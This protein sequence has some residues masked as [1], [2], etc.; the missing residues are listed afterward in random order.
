MLLKLYEGSRTYAPLWSDPEEFHEACEYFYIHIGE[1]EKEHKIQSLVSTG[2]YVHFDEDLKLVKKATT[3]FCRPWPS[4]GTGSWLSGLQRGSIMYHEGQRTLQKKYLTERLASRLE[5]HE[6]RAELTPEDRSFVENASFFFLATAD[7][8]GAPLCS[9]KGGLP[10]FVKVMN[11]RELAF[12]SYD[13]NGTFRSMGNISVNQQI[14]LLFIDFERGE[15]TLVEA[16]AEISADPK[17]LSP[18][19]DAQMAVRAH[20]VRVFSAC[21][22]YIHRLEM[23][24]LS[25]YVP[26]RGY[27]VPTPEWKSKPQYSEVLPENLMVTRTEKVVLKKENKVMATTASMPISE[28][29]TMLQS[30]SIFEII[31]DL[32]RREVDLDSSFEADPYLLA[33]LIGRVRQLAFDATR[34][35]GYA[36]NRD[37]Q[38]LLYRWLRVRHSEGDEYYELSSWF[39][40]VGLAAAKVWLTNLLTA[41]SKADLPAKPSDFDSW[42]EKKLN[43]HTAPDHPVYAYLETQATLEDFRHFVTQEQTVDADFADLIALSQ[44]GPDSPWK[45]AMA[46]NY[47][48]EMGAGKPDRVHAVMFRQVMDTVGAKSNEEELS[49]NSMACGNLLFLSSSRRRYFNLGIGALAATEL[50]VPKRFK[51]IANGTRRLGLPNHVTEYYAMHSEADTEHAQGWLCD[52]IR[53]VCEKNHGALKEVATGVLLRLE[54]SQRYCDELLSTMRKPRAVAA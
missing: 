29:R 40:A 32:G 30:Q 45:H 22:R 26:K 28:M 46:D 12:P 25:R 33:G 35:G 37:L 18:W 36:A 27:K 17:L 5:Q 42:L 47:W 3:I 24:G 44:V 7:Q 11:S 43:E 2:Q 51:R 9:Y 10:G 49:S 54:T 38:K 34:D 20:I 48:D 8:N 39:N 14:A 41:V 21:S 31:D 52:V 6:A 19:V 1:A 53:P 16:R 23:K 15:R 4:S 13:G 50:A